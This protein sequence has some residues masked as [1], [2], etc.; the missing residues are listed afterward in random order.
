M[1]ISV[2]ESYQFKK[3]VIQLMY[4]SDINFNLLKVVSI[5]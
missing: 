3:Y 1:N 2:P 5:W 4:T